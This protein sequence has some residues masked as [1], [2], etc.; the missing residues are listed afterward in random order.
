MS[1]SA[2]DSCCRPPSGPGQAGSSPTSVAGIVESC[3]F[4]TAES[5][6]RAGID[7]A[8]SELWAHAVSGMIRTVGIWWLESRSLPGTD[9]PDT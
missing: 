7:P 4:A 8:L 9:S 5:L 2:I 3:A 1:L 6:R